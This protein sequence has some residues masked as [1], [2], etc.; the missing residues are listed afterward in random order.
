MCINKRSFSLH[1]SNRMAIL[2]HFDR[3]ALHGRTRGKDQLL[4]QAW[5]FLDGIPDGTNAS[6]VRIDL[7][8]KEIILEVGSFHDGVFGNTYLGPLLHGSW[9]PDK[10]QGW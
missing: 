5:Y 2:R 1:F 10:A 7:D 6:R 4:T 8:Y 3:I 9:Q